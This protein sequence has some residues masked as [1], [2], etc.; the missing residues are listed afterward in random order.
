MEDCIDSLEYLY[1]T[2]VLQEVPGE[3]SLSFSINGCP[4]NC[5]HCS[6]KA[7]KDITPAKKLTDEAFDKFLMKNKGLAS[8]VLFLGGEWKKKDLV[9]KLKRARQM[10]FKTCLYTG[11]ETLDGVDKEIKDQ[12]SYIKVGSYKEELGGLNSKRTN[13]KFINLMTGKVMNSEF[14]RSFAF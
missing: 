8:C 4:R 2:I 10:G 14:Q 3:I 5:K 13:Q 7:S 6:W 12:L 11:I 1:S 9:K